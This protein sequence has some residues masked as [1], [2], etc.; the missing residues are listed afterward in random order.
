[1]CGRFSFRVVRFSSGKF[2]SSKMIRIELM[3][4]LIY[5]YI[6]IVSSRYILELFLDERIKFWE[7]E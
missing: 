2:S 5:I 4:N 7:N 6:Y 1:M 3:K